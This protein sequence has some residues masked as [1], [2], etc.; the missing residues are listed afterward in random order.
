MGGG[1][2]RRQRRRPLLAA[3]LLWITK[4]GL[5]L[6]LL[7]S[8][9][10]WGL[11]ASSA[12]LLPLGALLFVDG[13]EA[14][15]MLEATRPLHASYKERKHRSQASRTEG[16]QHALLWL[17]G[18]VSSLYALVA[19]V[20]SVS[21]LIECPGST[22]SM[23]NA[24]HALICHDSF[25]FAVLVAVVYAATATILQLPLTALLVSQLPSDTSDYTN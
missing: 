6:V 5:H 24:T 15:A 7:T 9:L 1:M 12:L 20:V 14:P 17:G 25:A 3:F 11:H 19:T 13:L 22:H 21:T 8:A 10:V 16:A 18:A 2:K 23:G 4:T